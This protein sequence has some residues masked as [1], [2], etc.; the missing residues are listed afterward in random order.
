MDYQNIK[1]YRKTRSL[2]QNSLFHLWT[3]GISEYLCANGAHFTSEQLKEMLK[4]TFL[5]SEV[6]ERI[7]VTTQEPESVRVLRKTSKLDTGKYYIF[8]QRVE[9][10]AA[11]VGC[12]VT[13]P[14]N[15]QY[16][17]LKQ[18]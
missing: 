16:M 1:P 17:K 5:D 6:I 2:S 13:I 11:G 7:D 8:M 3:G 10:W 9:C 14:Q 12:F 15:S 4:H 18:E